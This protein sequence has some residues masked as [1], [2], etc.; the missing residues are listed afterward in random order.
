MELPDSKRVRK[1][2]RQDSADFRGHWKPKATR[3]RFSSSLSSSRMSVNMVITHQPSSLLSQPSS[4]K[5]RRSHIV[6]SFEKVSC[7][8]SKMCSAWKLQASPTATG[9][10]GLGQVRVASVS[11]SFTGMATSV[12]SPGGWLIRQGISWILKGLGISC[13]CQDSHGPFPSFMRSKWFL[14]KRRPTSPQPQVHSFVSRHPCLREPFGGPTG[15][16]T[17]FCE[18]PPMLGWAFWL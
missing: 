12:F 11:L 6:T 17:Q 8:S 15:P 14:V 4:L 2:S 7:L 13:K 10:C 18:L 16:S 9:L 5:C 1:M 3:R